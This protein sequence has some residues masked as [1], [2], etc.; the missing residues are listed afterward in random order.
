MVRWIGVCVLAGATIGVAAQVITPPLPGTGPGQPPGAPSPKPAA[1]AP[2][3]RPKSDPPPSAILGQVFDAKSGRPVAKAIVRLL[4]PSGAVVQT[5]LADDRGRF[6]FKGV[7]PGDFTIAAERNGYFKGAL[8]QRR[9]SGEG[10]AITVGTN[11]VLGNLRLDVFRPSVITGSVFDEGGDP[12]VGVAVHA[13][14][15][16]F[17]DGAWRLDD[18]GTDETDDRGNYRLGDLMPGEYIVAVPTVKLAIPNAVAV[19]PGET[20]ID[21][22]TRL[23]LVMKAF[24]PPTQNGTAAA[25]ASAT[26]FDG[27][28]KNTLVTGS[29]PVPP[30]RDGGRVLAYANSYYTGADLLR[31]AMPVAVGPGETR[32]AVTFYLRP[33]PTA[34]VSG[35]LLGTGGGAPLRPLRL[36]VDGDDD[37]GFGTEVAAT[38]TGA[39]GSFTFLDVPQGRYIV[40]ARATWPTSSTSWIIFGDPAT[41]GVSGWA[42]ESITVNNE[43]LEGIA[44]TLSAPSALAGYI[45]YDSAQAA[46]R[47]A[48]S[49]LVSIS[50]VGPAMFSL[51]AV[52][53]DATRRFQLTALPP[54][55]YVLRVRDVPAGWSLK[56]AL[57]DGID[58]ADSAF[59]LRAGDTSQMTITLTDR[60]TKAIGTVR[61]VRGFVQP[62]ASVLAF[63]LDRRGIAGAGA[64]PS[65]LREA[66]VSGSG[67]FRIDGLPAGD[68]IFVAIDDAEAEGWQDETRLAKLAPLGTRVR[69]A[70]GESRTIDLRQV[71]A[72]K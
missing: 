2:A 3:P 10:T 15:R 62:T 55:N 8:G 25:N 29:G 16:Q 11:G 38:L 36:L 24:A 6:Y 23:D 53:P 21:V 9:A 39:D 34:R 44:V 49:M 61:D 17:A 56:S 7:M 30:P 70:A 66:R 48:G 35:R 69:L 33:V 20:S 59:T 18:F 50:P 41:H 65:R 37:L 54:G 67:V 4:S 27:D 47:T 5:R 19:S 63:P 43:D 51:P 22:G 72:R 32:D 58:V 14:R 46:P 1:A 40:E 12:I 42:R 31:L 26:I 52:T 71:T 68:Y 13:L 45:A 28:Q 64:S 57:L 60:I